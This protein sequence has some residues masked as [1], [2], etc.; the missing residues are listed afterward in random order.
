MS[1]IE[2]LIKLKDSMKD[3]PAPIIV[4]ISQMDAKPEAPTVFHSQ[5]EEIWLISRADF[6]EIEKRAILD[7]TPRLTPISWGA[8]SHLSGLP[9]YDLSSDSGRAPEIRDRIVE[10]I[11]GKENPALGVTQGL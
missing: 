8:F 4:A 7:A 11:L 1:L 10:A 5:G 3:A 9:V 6:R 2:D